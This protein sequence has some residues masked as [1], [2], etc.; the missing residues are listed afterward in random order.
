MD[1]PSLRGA[2]AA[3]SCDV[4]F[5]NKMVL[6]FVVGVVVGDTFVAF[7]CDLTSLLVLEKADTCLCWKEEVNAQQVRSTARKRFLDSLMKI[8]VKE[9][10]CLSSST[11]RLFVV[12][13]DCYYLL[14]IIRYLR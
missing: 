5:E 1:G 6:V 10:I 2:V 4:G 3:T 12:F 7:V 9:M 8:I 11:V 13:Y 14:F